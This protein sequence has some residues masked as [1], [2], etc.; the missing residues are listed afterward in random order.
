MKGFFDIE[1][2]KSLNALSVSAAIRD[3][4]VTCFEILDFKIARELTKIIN[5]D[6]N[7]CV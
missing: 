5:G 3:V 1:N 4:T 6:F 7:K 2:A